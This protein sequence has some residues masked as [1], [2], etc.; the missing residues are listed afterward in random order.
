MVVDRAELGPVA[1]R[2]LEVVAEDLFVL[3]EP[4]PERVGEPGDEAFVQP[5]PGALEQAGVRRVADQDV[6]EVEVVGRTRL[7]PADELFVA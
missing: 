3:G 6:A 7:R 1:K 2:L 4:G 5:G